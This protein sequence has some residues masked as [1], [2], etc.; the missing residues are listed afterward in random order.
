MLQDMTIVATL[1]TPIA[2]E[3][4][5]MTLLSWFASAYLIASAASQPVAGKLTDIFSRR[6]GL[7]FCNIFFGA[8]CLICAFARN[9]VT[10]I[11]GRAVSGIGGGG[12]NAIGTFVCSDLLPLRKR[13]LWQ[14]IGNITFGVGMSLGGFIGGTIN[15]ALG[16]RYA[17]LLQTPLTLISGMLVACLLKVPV[18]QT[19]APGFKRIDFLGATLLILSLIL[20]LLG[21]NTGGN[22]LPWGHPL[23]LTVLPLS[24]VLFLSFLY[25]EDKV[26]LEPIIPVGLLLNRTVFSTCIT[27][28][29]SMMSTCIYQFYVPYFVQMKGASAT[30]AGLRLVPQALSSSLGSFISGL[31]MQST[32]RYYLMN[33]LG[34]AIFVAGAALVSTLDFSS[35]AWQT[36]VFL[37]PIG[38]GIGSML[39]ITLVALVAAVDHKDQAVIT[40]A[41]YAFRSTGSTIGI[42]LGSVVFQNWLNRSLMQILSQLPEKELVVK[43]IRDDY[44]Q[45]AALP[46]ALQQEATDCYMG[47]FRATF[48]TALCL[49]VLAGLVSLWMKEHKLHDTLARE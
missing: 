17:F 5:S 42:T 47:A 13:G 16:W 2:S 46:T 9:E 23:V 34:M 7:L 33:C 30:A 1:V 19:P 22:Q 40:S 31:L 32:G 12:L 27:N 48:V 24:V 28:L 6:S 49:L 3:F 14:G 8:G 41:S 36:F 29:L 44:H 45:I 43:A 10:M 25:V 21:L 38:W 11:V 15:D 20:L 37:V 26:A 35:P 39:V 4:E 18:K